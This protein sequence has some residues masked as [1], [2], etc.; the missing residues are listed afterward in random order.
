MT[1]RVAVISCDTDWVEEQTMREAHE[2]LVGLGKPITY[3]LTQ[4][5]GFQDEPGAVPLEFAPHPNLE[6]RALEPAVEASMAVT[7]GAVSFRAHSLQYSSRLR[8]ILRKHGIRFSSSA[9]MYLQPGIRAYPLGHELTEVPLF[10][11]DAFH[12]EYCE[13]GRQSA[14]ELPA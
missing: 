11:M 7:P 8:P 12:L 6:G 10:W 5:Y 14:L 4:R 9:M 1:D 13:L 3:F 2:L